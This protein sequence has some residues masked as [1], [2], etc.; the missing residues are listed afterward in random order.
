MAVIVAVPAPTAFTTPF[1]TVAT[2]SF[3]DSHVMMY[4]SGSLPTVAVMVEVAPLVV[5]LTLLF[6][7]ESVGVAA[8]AVDA[9]VT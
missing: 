2:S 4:S 8:A 6:D 7:K 9:T 1:S 3:D 5:R